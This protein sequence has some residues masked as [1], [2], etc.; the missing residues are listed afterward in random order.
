MTDDV[1]LAAEQ[2]ARALIDRQLTAAGWRVQDRERLNLYAGTG[3]AVREAIMAPGR[4]RTD[5]RVREHRE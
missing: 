5:A 3:V 2:R 1:R 4:C